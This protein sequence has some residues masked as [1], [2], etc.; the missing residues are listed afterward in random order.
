MSR[1]PNPLERKFHQAALAAPD[2][3]ISQKE[4]DRLGPDPPARTAAIN[5][6]LGTGLFA[7][8][9]GEGSR[10]LYRAVSQDELETKKALGREETL[11]LN[12]IRAAGNQG[13]WTKHVK[14]QTQLHQTV[15]D[16]CLKSLT[17]KQLIRT[18]NDVR[19][20]TRKIYMLAH[21]EP[22]VELTGG[23]WYTDKELDAEFIKLLSDV[24]LKIVRDHSF[25]KAT[26]GEDTP[27]RQLYPL[28]HS[29]YPTASQILEL[30]KKI[31]V[32]ETE[33]TV[34]HVEMILEVLILDGKTEKI[35]A[36]HVPEP[37]L[38][39]DQ[40]S[41]EEVQHSRKASNRKR[42]YQDR[43]MEPD[44]R[45]RRRSAAT[46]SEDDTST[47]GED[48]PL[49]KRRRRHHKGDFDDSFRRKRKGIGRERNARSSSDTEDETDPVGDGPSGSRN[50]MA[51]KSKDPAGPQVGEMGGPP[52]PSGFVYRAVYEERVTLGLNQA[53]CTVCPVSDFCHEEGP[54]NPQGCVYYGT[55]P[56]VRGAWL[57]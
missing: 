7:L 19:H 29:S 56:S 50:I 13:I 26:Q 43:N 54:V 47:S 10:I 14:A 40:E 11:V 45:R 53:P 49:R 57:E 15:L 46:D 42:R 37:A 20:T 44:R 25:P 3:I 4:I 51:R 9:A 30:I 16:R 5:F 17:Q 6:L 2:K 35:P 31:R 36:F 38:D 28:T 48:R 21:L 33:L 55:W 39:E 41:R 1:Q 12:R 18:V 24:C 27:V 52:L 23:P 34:H 8:L 22:S 32:T